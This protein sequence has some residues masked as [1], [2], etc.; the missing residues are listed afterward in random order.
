MKIS[1]H[2]QKSKYLTLSQTVLEMLLR[3]LWEVG[4]DKLT[5]VFSNETKCNGNI[6]LTECKFVYSCVSKFLSFNL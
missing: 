5:V 2:N 3:G 6:Q 1:W 4:G